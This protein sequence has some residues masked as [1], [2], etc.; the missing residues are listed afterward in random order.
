MVLIHNILNT[1]TS[2]TTVAN[3]KTGD[4]R[5]KDGHK[6]GLSGRVEIC[7][8]EQWG[9]VCDDYWGSSEAAVV[10]KQLNY[11]SKGL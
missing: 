4:L 3:C 7:V 9:T 1:D 5:L 2:C 10:C 8:Q 11:S 6:S